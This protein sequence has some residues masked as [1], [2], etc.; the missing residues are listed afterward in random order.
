VTHARNDVG[1]GYASR[2]AFGR[3]AGEHELYPELEK[4]VREFEG[5]GYNNGPVL[6]F[7]CEA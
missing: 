6:N 4:A 2:D 7:V 1:G 3:A 5:D